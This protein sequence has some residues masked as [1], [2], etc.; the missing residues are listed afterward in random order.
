MRNCLAIYAV[1]AA[2]TLA[3]CAC[4]PEPAGS[5]G[6]I[7]AV[8]GITESISDPQA[9]DAPVA[10]TV[11]ATVPAPAP[12]STAATTP[13]VPSTGSAPGSAVPA[14]RAPFSARFSGALTGGNFELFSLPEGF[15]G[16]RWTISADQATSGRSFIVAL[17]DAQERM[18]QRQVLIANTYF[19]HIQ[20]R[21]GALVLG[22]TPM[23]GVAGGAF[24]VVASR[25]DA[26]A[27]PAP[28]PQQVWLNFGPG[29]NV[30][31]NGRNSVSFSA[32]DAGTLDSVYVGQ[33]S[34]MKQ[35]IVDTMREDYAP[36]Q[37]IIS[38]SDE[39][40]PPGGAYAA[41][42]FGAD[43]AQLLGLA[44]NVD[45]YNADPAQTAI[46]FV[47][48]FA[49]YA[50]MRLE[51]DEMGVMIGN[52]ASHELGHLLG[53][54]HTKLPTNIMD[55]TGTAWEL[56]GEQ[57]FRLAPLEA[58]VFP[59]GYEDADDLL[60]LTVGRQAASSLPKP[61]TAKLARKLDLRAKIEAELGSRCG[62]C[63][64]LNETP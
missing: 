29:V 26:P 25:D 32:F 38:T 12:T 18:V 64:H 36:Y 17:F 57:D 44:D 8:A 40:G 45:Q 35:A 15:A 42:H 37:V 39:G 51:A 14:D 43:D 53:L 52:T 21:D 9:P 50:A 63:L 49:D 4:G 54:F 55:T 6:G 3:L 41:I 20:R 10:G 30:K 58:S 13:E 19:E 24:G 23:S 5:N 28:Q 59:I 62:T 31:V 22:V 48:A 16:E 46:V 7:T 11:V 61:A 1:V 2:T 47:E 56:A 33:T 27:L 34:A 60:S